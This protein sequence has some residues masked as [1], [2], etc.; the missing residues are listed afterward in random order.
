M[1]NPRQK[2]KIGENLV[3]KFLD[4]NTNYTW[5]FTPGS[6]SGI[7]KGDLH[8]KEKNNSFC[9][10]VKNYADSPISDKMLTNK[11]NDFVQWWTKLVLQSKNKHPLL[12]FKYNRSKLFVATSIKPSNVDNYLD[13]RGLDCYIMLAE[14]W[15][16]KEEIKWLVS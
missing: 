16:G 6:G 13:F 11:T 5:D 10:E 2:G 8:I 3:K 4:T 9:I 1:V 7:I 14:D 15:I 12:F